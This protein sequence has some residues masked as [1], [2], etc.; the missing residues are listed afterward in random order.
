M[1]RPQYLIDTN[2]VIEYL[3]QQLPA[4]GMEFMN[5]VINA[6]PTISV[7]TKIEVLGFNAPDNHYKLLTDFMD[8]AT[9]LDLSN[10]VVDATI[11]VRKTHK[12]KLPDAVIAATALVYDLILITHNISD[13]KKIEGLKVIDP[14]N[15]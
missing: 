11:Q 1:E 13:F 7:V 8:D 6:V 14:Y 12:T 3:G 4:S 15:A 9:V 5:E 2:A 10:K